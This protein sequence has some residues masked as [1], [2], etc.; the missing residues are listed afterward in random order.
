MKIWPALAVTAGL[1]ASLLVATPASA[2]DV[3]PSNVKVSWKDDTLTTVHVTWDEEGAHPNRVL[4][5]RAGLPDSGRIF[6]VPTD[7]PNEVDIPAGRFFGMGLAQ[8]GV[9]TGTESGDTSAMALSPR[10]DTDAPGMPTLVSSVVNGSNGLTVRWQPGKAPVDST[11]DDPLD[12]TVPPQFQARYRTV[13]SGQP[14]VPLGVPGPSTQVSF[15]AP[16]PKF[17]FSVAAVNEWGST[18]SLS[19]E[20][21]TV[22]PTIQVTPAWSRYGDVVE[23]TGTLDGADARQVI[24]QARN[25]STSPWYV[26]KANSF[27]S[28]YYFGFLGPAPRQYRVQVPNVAAPTRVWFGGFSPITV[29]VVQLRTQ[30]AFRA[31][32]LKRGQT[33]EAHVDVGPAADTTAVLQRWSGKTWTT[34]GPVAVRGGHGVGYV[35]AVTV[36][37]VAYRYYVPATV[38]RGA[39]Y[40]AAYSPNFVLTTI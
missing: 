16:A 40:Q 20:A 35:R 5:H 32:Q 14:L 6:L 4:L 3:A 17:L 23:V 25:S 39:T 30:G 7:A 37:R 21:R 36:G 12:R 1:A 29:S 8:I 2:A 9:S 27:N 18:A 11:P 31:S 22:D 26:V 10:F 33:G 15:T 13:G 19:L 34:V 28:E 24:L 38:Y